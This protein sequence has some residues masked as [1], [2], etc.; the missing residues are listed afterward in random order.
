MGLAPYFGKAALSGASILQ[1]ISAEAFRQRIERLAVALT[2]DERATDSVEGQHLLELAANLLARLYPTIGVF[3][4][5]NQRFTD[6]L[7]D[8]VL[9]LNP[10]VEFGA[11]SDHF[12]AQIIVGSP[13][14]RPPSQFTVYAGSSDW[15]LHVST[16]HPV[17]VG[18]CK[19]P[20]GAGAAACF[21]AAFVFRSLFAKEL[22]SPCPDEELCLSLARY[23]SGSDTTGPSLSSEIG[24]VA[25]VGNGAIGNGVIWSLARTSLRG[26]VHVIDPEEVDSGNPQ[27]YILTSPAEVGTQKVAIAANSLIGH[28]LKC[29]PHKGDW[30]EFLAKTAK[31][32]LPLVC[33]A[34]DTSFD[35]CAVQSSLPKYTLNAWTQPGDL[36]VSR[37]GFIDES[38]CLAC[39]YIPNKGR[40]SERELVASAIRW[41][42]DIH[43]IGHLLYFDAA[44]TRPILERIARDLG[45]QFDDLAQFEGKSLRGLY[46][47]GICGGLVTVSDGQNIEV[48]MAFQSALAGIM[49]AAEMVKFT[50]GGRPPKDGISTKIDLLGPL[51]SILS[52][53]E[54][55][56]VSSRCLCQDKDYLKAYKEKYPHLA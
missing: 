53:P 28:T 25:L 8:L 44:L 55:K 40:P 21:S 14:A 15:S 20:F 13:L 1:G 49:L 26:I 7:H 45:K 54:A 30:S 16:R 34:L 3:G 47:E 37:H 41:S 35:R 23:D 42:G 39:L 48:P 31:W 2:F 19:N 50:C 52:Q 11:H 22:N 36:G 6:H 27:R 10:N 24:E 32:N 9:R 46:R 33:T 43:E 12:N 4:P 51:G 29:V 17:T 38:A 56:H 5:T 18:Q